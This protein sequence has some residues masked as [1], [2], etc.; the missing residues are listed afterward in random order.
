MDLRRCLIGS[1]AAE[2]V[3]N[4]MASP[5]CLVRGAP[6]Y[7]MTPRAVMHAGVREGVLVLEFPSCLSGAT[8]PR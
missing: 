6:D 7:P 5:A 2:T 1:S 3:R 4:G 8:L